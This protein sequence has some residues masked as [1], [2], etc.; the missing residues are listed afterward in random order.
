MAGTTMTDKRITEEQVVNLAQDCFTLAQQ[1]HMVPPGHVWKI[2]PGSPKYGRLWI[3]SAET[4]SK[5]IY[6]PYF[7]NRGVLGK[8]A[9]QA[10]DFLCIVLDMLMWFEAIMEEK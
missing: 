9:K 6:Y 2:S 4:P 7:T 8:T 1:L 3:L 5:E 10:H